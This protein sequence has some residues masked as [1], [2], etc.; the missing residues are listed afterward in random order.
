[1]EAILFTML[2]ETNVHGMDA[3]GHTASAEDGRAMDGQLQDLLSELRL[4]LPS[5]NPLHRGSAPTVSAFF[6]HESS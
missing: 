2:K 4:C 6:R 3:I 1:M 5:S